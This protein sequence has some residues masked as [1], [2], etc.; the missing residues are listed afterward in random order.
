MRRA[1][2][3]RGLHVEASAVLV[4]NT[5]TDG[6]SKPRP[7]SDLFRREKRVEDFRQVISAMP[8]P[9]ASLDQNVAIFRCARAESHAASGIASMAFVASAITAC[10]NCPSSPETA[11]T[12][13][14]DSTRI[15]IDSPRRWCAMSL[16]ADCMTPADDGHAL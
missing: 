15:S 11:G 1:D 6:E 14:A 3:D 4:Y 5:I 9:V 8:T 16:A 10:C 7:A 2:P 12:S 13:S